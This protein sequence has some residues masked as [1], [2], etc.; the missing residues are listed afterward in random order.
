MPL[1]YMAAAVIQHF[2]DDAALMAM[3][4]Q[5]VGTRAPA[6]LTQ[7]FLR[8]QVPDNLILAAP[9]AYRPLVQVEALVSGLLVPGAP[10][11]EGLAWAGAEL[12]L[13]ALCSANVPYEG[14]HW[15]G[16]VFSGPTVLPDISRGADSPVYRGIV[17]ADLTVTVAA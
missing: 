16:R 2:L 17:R 11:P 8:V 12:A 5:R 9:A 4:G 15:T 14:C 10:D 3:F 7:P 1:P 6:S 13:R